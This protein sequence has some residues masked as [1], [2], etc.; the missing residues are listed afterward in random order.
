MSGE[1]VGTR[2]LDGHNTRAST[3]ALSSHGPRPCRP[4]ASRQPA[5]RSPK[6]RRDGRRAGRLRVRWRFIRPTR[7]PKARRR[8][9][10]R[11]DVGS[12]VAA[13]YRPPD[14]AGRACH[15][16]ARTH[17]AWGVGATSRTFDVVTR[18]ALPRRTC[19]FGEVHLVLRRSA[20]THSAKCTWSFGEVDSGRRALF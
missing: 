1:R 4:E 16:H 15:D 13:C 14:G 8:R 9:H 6:F 17:R 18:R 11:P 10:V 3:L 5:H 2:Q 7:L 19:S 12:I 20:P